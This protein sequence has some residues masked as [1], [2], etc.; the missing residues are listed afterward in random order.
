MSPK[1]SEQ[2]RE[3]KRKEILEAAKRVFIRKGYRAATMKDVVEEAGL[4]RGGVYLYF[5]STEEMFLAILAELD[6]ENQLDFD[7]AIEECGSIWGAVRQL[8]AQ[9]ER[10]AGAV[11][12][13]MLQAVLE[14]FFFNGWERASNPLMETRYDRSVE[15]MHR[16]IQTGVERGEFTP[17]VPTEALV[18]LVISVNDGILIG[19]TQIGGGRMEVPKQ[20]D[21]LLEA[22]KH[23]LQ[24]KENPPG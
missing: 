8:F 15:F 13:S 7:R 19:A 2:Q 22:L 20:L 6:E 11:K 3:T 16:F 9:M 18:K 10:E 14:Y 24:V 1:I 5:G 17:I 12:E 4:S 23:L 21:V